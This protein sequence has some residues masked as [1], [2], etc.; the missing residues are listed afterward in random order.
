M[1]SADNAY[2]RS[3]ERK[4]IIQSPISH[5]IKQLA[6]GNNTVFKLSLYALSSCS[7]YAWL[8]GVKE[9]HDTMLLQKKFILMTISVT[10]KLPQ[11][12]LHCQLCADLLVTPTLLKI[13]NVTIT[14][15][16]CL[17]ARDSHVCTSGWHALF[18]NSSVTGI[19]MQICWIPGDSILVMSRGLNSVLCLRL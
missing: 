5:P 18:P 17:P 7:A 1:S 14:I 12:W 19:H 11:G 16:V 3:Q 15:A 13:F 2:C 6:L 4:G 10:E 9:G 8:H